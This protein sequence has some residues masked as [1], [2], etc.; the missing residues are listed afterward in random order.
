MK[1]KKAKKIL[2]IAMACTMAMSSMTVLAADTPLTT[3]GES[4]DQTVAGDVNYVD[5]TIFKVT[6]P[7]TT[8]LSFA[9]D[10]QGLSTLDG[11]GTYDATKS[12]LVVG[13]GTMQAKN[14]S[15]VDVEITGSFYID[16]TNTTKTTLLSLADKDNINNDKQELCLVLQEKPATGDNKDLIAITSN[17]ST[18]KTDY[19]FTL[20]KAAYE[21]KAK[22]GGG[23]E[24]VLKTTPTDNYTKTDLTL[25]GVVAKDFDWTAYTGTD[26]KVLTLHAVFAFD[27]VSTTPAMTLLDNG[28]LVYDFPED[29]APTGTLTALKVNDVVKAGMVSQGIATYVASSNRFVIKVTGVATL[30]ATG[31]IVATIGDTDYTFTYTK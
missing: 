4:G 29:S 10:P 8:A 12:G 18:K 30:D 7:T 21:F 2:A 14:E 22:S 19:S 3:P 20:G 5:T 9:L 24:Y 25:G 31:T 1:F 27:E 15:S 26:K 11:S 6:L 16:D 13:T 23:Y 17:E 28:N